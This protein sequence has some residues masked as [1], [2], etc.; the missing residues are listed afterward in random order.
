[1]SRTTERE[2]IFKLLYMSAFYEK[3]ELSEE[4]LL[5]FD[6]P[7]PLSDDVE[8]SEEI[9]TLKESLKDSE[10]N[11]V[12]TKYSMVVDKVS[13]IDAKISSVSKGWSLDR[14]GKIELAILRLAIYEIEYD[15]EVPASVAIN[16]AVELAKKYGPGEAYAFVNGILSQFA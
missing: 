2:L 13:E 4:L 7:F 3:K 16:E 14:I 1:M 5:Y 6:A 12:V 11:N 8:F 10:R 9:L 15:D